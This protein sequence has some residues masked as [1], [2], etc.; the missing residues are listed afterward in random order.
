MLRQGPKDA[1]TI[2][3]HVQVVDLE[4]MTLDV[5]PPD[6]LP[7]ADLTQRVAATHNARAVMKWVEQINP[8]PVSTWFNAVY[9]YRSS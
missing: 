4:P 5:I 8:K 3:V 2:P 7:A 6:Y 1:Q 9:S